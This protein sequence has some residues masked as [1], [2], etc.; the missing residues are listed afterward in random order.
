MLHLPAAVL[1]TFVSALAQGP[2]P[3]VNKAGTARWLV[4]SADFA[5]Q[6]T[7]SKALEGAPFGNVQSMSDGT[8]G[9]NDNSTGVPYFYVS[10]L[11]TSM[12]DI[13]AN[14]TA[15]ISITEEM[16]NATCTTKKWDD[17]DPR[18]ARV[19][20]TGKMVEVT[21]ADEAAQA[22]AALFSRHPAMAGWPGDHSFA[23]WKLDINNIWLIDFF[24]GAANITTADYFKA[25][26]LL[27]AHHGGVVL[28]SE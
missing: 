3:F 20:L 2:P 10:P 12:V 8:V 11:D 21:D 7:I 17:E 13:A 25:E 4:H 23:F 5:F 1:G 14:P 18:C 22:K 9:A 16:I 15:S 28:T 27:P 19:T 24:G 26:P 6:A